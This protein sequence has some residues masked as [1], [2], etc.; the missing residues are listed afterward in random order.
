MDKI[1]TRSNDNEIR[2]SETGDSKRFEGYAAVFHTPLDSRT[3]YE[4]IP[5]KLWERIMPTAFHESLNGNREILA[6]YEHDRKAIM[7]RTSGKRSLRLGVDDKGLKFELDYDGADPDH[8]KALAKIRGSAQSKGMSFGFTV[9]PGGDSFIREG[10][11]DI[12][13]LKNIRL[14]EITLTGTP[15]YAAANVSMR[16]EGSDTTILAAYEEWAET[17]RLIEIAESYQL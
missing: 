17:Q 15:A 10:G 1:E 16:S 9:P 6:L 4:L 2:I 7:G 5:G 12:R 3:E 8:R 14:H 11:R 13:Q